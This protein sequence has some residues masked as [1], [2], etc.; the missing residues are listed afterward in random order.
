MMTE[1]YKHKEQ[2]KYIFSVF[3]TAFEPLEE[4]DQVG[5][6]GALMKRLEPHLGPEISSQPPERFVVHYEIIIKAYIQSVE[7]MNSLFRSL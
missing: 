1:Q 6:M 7:R 3:K 5:L 4:K 2:E